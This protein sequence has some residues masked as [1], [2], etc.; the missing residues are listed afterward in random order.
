MAVAPAQ[1]LVFL[2][3]AVLQKLEAAAV[4]KPTNAALVVRVL[5][6][7]KYA[8]VLRLKL[9]MVRSVVLAANVFRVLLALTFPIAEQLYA[10]PVALVPPLE[11]LVTVLK[12]VV[13][14]TRYVAVAVNA[15][16]Q[17]SFV[18]VPKLLA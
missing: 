5:Q 2:A 13:L 3:L 9:S 4:E 1:Q 16:R 15:Q 10:A 8:T 14:I 18:I 6:M 12:C 17:V 7:E 11:L